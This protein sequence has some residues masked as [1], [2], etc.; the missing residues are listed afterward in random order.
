MDISSKVI[1]Q[2]DII[3]TGMFYIRE[4]GDVRID[5]FADVY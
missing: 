1:W 3:A 4:V 2:D 5:R